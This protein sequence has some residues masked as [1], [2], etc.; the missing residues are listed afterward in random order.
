MSR[1]TLADMPSQVGKTAVVTGSTSGVGLEAAKA[2]AR[3][4]AAVVIAARNPEKGATVA[5][6]ICSQYVPGATFELVDL[7]S[8][9]S[10]GAFA[11]RLTDK[12]RSIDILLN[13]AGL[14]MIPKRLE[15]QDGFELQFGTNHLGHFALTRM[16]WPLLMASRSARV[17]TVSSLAHRRG[18][19]DFT[20]INSLHSYSPMG[21]YAQS[22]L[23]NLMFALELQ[24][25]IDGAGVSNVISVAAHPGL[26]ATNLY[27]TGQET[28][29]GGNRRRLRTI[30]GNVVLRIIGMRSEQGA[31]PLVYAA[32]SESASG[33]GYYGPDSR[34]EA[35]GWPSA[36]RISANALDREAA[37]R[38]W[39][40]SE[41]LTGGAFDVR[42]G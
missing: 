30:I 20:D 2:L 40:L 6:Q 19:L 1:W 13:N 26:T 8:L 14:M 5:A 27:V 36:A 10:V 28:G 22:K 37:Q 16:L 4:G 34:S 11:E 21:A 15:T 12:L 35:R 41:D 18:P 25:R 38:L 3:A 24:R 32:V 33:G 42:K 29:A 17:V 9:A 23:A 39:S 7:S 31:L